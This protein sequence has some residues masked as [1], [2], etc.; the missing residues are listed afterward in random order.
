MLTEFLLRDLIVSSDGLPS[1]SGIAREFALILK[2]DSYLAG[3]W[4]G[5]IWQGLTRRMK[6]MLPRE[7]T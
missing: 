3:I 5:N 4:R 6:I 7:K 2:H 1:M